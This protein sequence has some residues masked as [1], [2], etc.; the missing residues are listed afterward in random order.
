M[1]RACLRYLEK[2]RREPAR[3]LLARCGGNPL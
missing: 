1:L 3:T 2:E